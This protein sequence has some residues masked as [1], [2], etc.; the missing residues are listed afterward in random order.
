MAIVQSGY[1]AC[2]GAILFNSKKQILIGKRNTQKF[3]CWQFPQGGVE[4]NETFHQAAHR[5]ACEELG[6]P[7][8]ALTHVA[9]ID[10]IFYYETPNNSWLA[11]NGFKG[12]AIS[13]SVFFWDG[14]LG[15]CDLTIS[16]DPG[17]PPEFSAVDWMNAN[18]WDER[19]MPYVV[20]FKKQLYSQLKD[21]VLRIINNY[22]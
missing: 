19:L 17:S 6:L 8:N 7:H 18:E 12:Q 13:F 4:E 2:S 14:M 9:S 20:E 1:R 21:Q 10:R 3:E 15:D 11:H 5:E 16:H 22:V